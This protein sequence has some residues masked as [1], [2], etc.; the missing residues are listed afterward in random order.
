MT[1]IWRKFFASLKSQFMKKE[2]SLIQ[3]E[4]S[5]LDDGNLPNLLTITQC[6]T[7]LPNIR[8][9]AQK[10]HVMRNKKPNGFWKVD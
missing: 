1:G 8:P 7:L 4:V 5:E 3:A 6:N 2:I 10:V 9:I